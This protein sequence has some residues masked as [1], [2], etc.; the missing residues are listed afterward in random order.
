VDGFLL[1]DKPSGWTSHDVVA[2]TRRLAGQRRIGHAGTLDPM[3]TGLL[4]LALGSAT[5]LIEYLPGEKA[6]R[7]EVA[8]G[9]RTDTDDA[10][11]KVLEQRAAPALSQADLASLGAR[12]TG[13]LEQVPPA[14][15]AVQV[16][17][18][19]SYVVARRGGR[20]ALA[21]RPI[22]VYRLELAIARPGVLEIAIECSAGTYVR[23][24]ARD[25]GEAL[26]CGAHLLSLR[27]TRS[28]RFGLEDAWT[29]DDLQVLAGA[30]LLAEALLP[31]DEGAIDR[32]AAILCDA[33]A[34]ALRHGRS[35]AAHAHDTAASRVYTAAGDFV[36][37][38]SIREGMLRAE[39]VLP[40]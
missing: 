14:Y 36:G 37:I 18:E 21:A 32:P 17:G 4:V 9:A 1:V 25:I 29:L 12:F 30:G 6:Y 23:A 26:G 13:P 34:E 39:K 40:A 5:R 16:R 22:A 28:G 31:P 20:L 27:R 24:L 15:S 19:R 2:R 7:G 11:G 8:L 38:A 33:S 3:A 35:V 10:T